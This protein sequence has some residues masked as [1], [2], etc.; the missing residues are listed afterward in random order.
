M[1]KHLNLCSVLERVHEDFVG[2][3]TR[4]VSAEELNLRTSFC[5]VVQTINTA[6]LSIGK[7]QKFQVF[8]CFGLR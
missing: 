5:T 8:I 1:W 3:A 7:N 2:V 4:L 6:D